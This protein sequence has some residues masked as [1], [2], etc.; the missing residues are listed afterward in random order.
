MLP[1]PPLLP[2]RRHLP[3][4]LGHRKL[5]EWRKGTVGT[6]RL[7]A[8]RLPGLLG[9]YLVTLPTSPPGRRRHR[10]SY[11]Y[12]GNPAGSLFEGHTW[13]C[14]A[15][16]LYF[17]FPSIIVWKCLH[18]LLLHEDALKFLGN[19]NR[20]KKR[21]AE[22]RRDVSECR[23]F[24]KQLLITSKTVLASNWFIKHDSVTATQP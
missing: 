16:I 4:V 21:K 10:S 24:Q 20:I 17:S 5:S 8:A 13:S 23:S 14:Q 12:E 1:E 22:T 9:G 6:W 7:G 18:S 3:F 11:L 15:K 2:I 19:L